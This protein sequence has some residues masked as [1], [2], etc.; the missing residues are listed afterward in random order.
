MLQFLGDCAKTGICVVILQALEGLIESRIKLRLFRPKSVIDSLPDQNTEKADENNSCLLIP[1]DWKKFREASIISEQAD[2]WEPSPLPGSLWKL[3]E[4]IMLSNTQTSTQSVQ[5]N[6]SS[7]RCSQG[8]DKINLQTVMQRKVYTWQRI[9][10]KEERM[11][12]RKVRRIALWNTRN[13]FPL[14]KW[15]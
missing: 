10:S 12:E 13:L 6:E 11:G 4:M 14:Y 15:K 1:E 7:D 2:R 8:K 3:V 5:E 9:Q